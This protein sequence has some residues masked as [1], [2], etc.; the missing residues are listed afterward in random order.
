MSRDAIVEDPSIMQVTRLH[1]CVVVCCGVTVCCGVI[2]VLQCVVCLHKCVVIFNG[3]EVRYGVAVCGGV[4]VVLQCVA[5]KTTS[6][7]SD[8]PSVKWVH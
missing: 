1:R 5:C 7:F 3:V 8:D 2:A 6:A 4:V